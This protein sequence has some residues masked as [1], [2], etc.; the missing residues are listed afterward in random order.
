MIEADG[1]T[2]TDVQ[3]TRFTFLNAEYTQMKYG[4]GG[5]TLDYVDAQERP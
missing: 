3:V 5:L 4:L 2:Q 1:Q